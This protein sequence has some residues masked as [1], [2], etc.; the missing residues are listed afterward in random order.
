[1]TW[2][3]FKI[4]GLFLLAGIIGVVSFTLIYYS[5]YI[6]SKDKLLNYQDKGIVLTDRNG[7]SF[8]TINKANNGEYVDLSD[9]SP[10][11]KKAVVAVED[12]DFYH[13]GGISIKGIVR[14]VLMDF[15]EGKLAYGG[16]T[17]TQQLVKNTLLSSQK[18]FARKIKEAILAINVDANF[19]K[20]EILEMYLNTVYYGDGAV[21]ISEASKTYFNKS[22]K[23]LSLAQSAY[24][25]G[26][27]KSPNSFLPSKATDKKISEVKNDVLEKM[28]E[29]N[30]ISLQEKEKGEGTELSFDLNP[31]NP[32]NEAPDFALMVEKKLK[33]MYGPDVIYQ[34]LTVKTTLNLSWQEYVQ[35]AIKKGVERVSYGNVSNGAAVVMNPTNGQILALVGSKDWSNPDFGKINM[36]IT[37]RQPGSSFKPI[38]YSLAMDEDLI[39]PATVLSDEPTT[40]KLSSD[41]DTSSPCVYK[42]L[43]F[44]KHFRGKVTVRRA[45]ANSL[46]IPSVEVMQKLGVD[47]LVARASDFGITTFKDAKYYGKGLSLVLGSQEVPPV[48]MADAY[49]TFANGGKRPDPVMILNVKDKFGKTIYES[50]PQFTQVITPGTAYLITSILSDNYTRSEEFGSLLSTPFPAAVKTGTSENIRD[51]WTIGYTPNLLAAVWVGNDNGDYMYGLTGSLAAAPIWKDIMQKF[52]LESPYQDFSKPE[53]VVRATYCDKTSSNS[54][55]MDFFL[56]GTQPQNISCINNKDKNVV[57]ENSDEPN[58]PQLGGEDGSS[59]SSSSQ[60]PQTLNAITQ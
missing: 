36:A 8:Y 25:A 56:Q 51:A 29:D 38:V 10:N 11:M 57:V 31:Q 20:D 7:A 15:K 37:P 21:G 42:P 30:L 12:R 5:P 16:S 46:N 18:T 27:L 6:K 52:V 43:D 32:V 34:G 40:F 41:C 50:S 53:G 45:L 17:I 2:Q 26:I 58:I 49:A 13:N 44:D 60:S 59:A 24:L 54:A 55:K 14:S 39:T 33:E 22:P 48:E 1:M 23:D 28:Y 9:I 47:T 4:I 3:L 35:N 19:S